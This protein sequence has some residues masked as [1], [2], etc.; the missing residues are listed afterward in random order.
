[1]SRQLHKSE[2]KLHYK[3]KGA[4]LSGMTKHTRKRELGVR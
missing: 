3:R 2:T 1:M 4:Y